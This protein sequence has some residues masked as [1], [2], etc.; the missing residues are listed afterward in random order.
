MGK[1]AQ[2]MKDLQLDNSRHASINDLPNEI[3]D[4]VFLYIATSSEDIT[5]DTKRLLRDICLL[6][7]RWCCVAQPLL[8]NSFSLY[9]ASRNRYDDPLYLF[10]RSLIE[11]PDLSSSIKQIYLDQDLWNVDANPAEVQNP[12]PEPLQAQILEAARRIRSVD[13]KWRA[14]IAKNRCD[15]VTALL[16][17]LLPNLRTLK[18]EAQYAD[19]EDVLNSWVRRFAVEFTAATGYSSTAWEFLPML[20]TIQIE[21]LDT[22]DGFNFWDSMP[23]VSLPTIRE[24]QTMRMGSCYKNGLQDWPVQH[25]SATVLHLFDSSACGEELQYL[26][27][28]FKAIEVI[29]WSWA[30]V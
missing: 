12:V 18:F 9:R 25:S 30:D 24:V 10:I 20:E 3:L 4:H 29:E 5:W 21:Y 17:C 1:M 11:R 26:L 2:A 23:L 13:T 28:S 7:R 15:A 14:A 19:E 16:F 8:F 6:G 27:G 22:E